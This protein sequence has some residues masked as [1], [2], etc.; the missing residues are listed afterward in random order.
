M[1]MPGLIT[2]LIITK[3]NPFNISQKLITKAD[4]ILPILSSF[5]FTMLGFLVTALAVILSLGGTT[6]IKN[7]KHYGY[8]NI[9]GQ[10]YIATLITLLITF[11]F[12]TASVLF[13]SGLAI[14]ISLSAI[15][16]MQFL[17]I[18]ITSYNLM[19]KQ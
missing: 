8:F 16:I 5:S 13:T 1:I 18:A 9:F 4:V 12:A 7:F 10:I 19:F 2:Y 14:L 15:N 11:V 6:F 17:I 3:I